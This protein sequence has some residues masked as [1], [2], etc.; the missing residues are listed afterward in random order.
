VDVSLAAEPGFRKQMLFIA[1]HHLSCFLSSR[2]N[3]F[4]IRRNNEGPL[5]CLPAG[6]SP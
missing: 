5:I 6:L 4:S 2:L 1:E 3:R